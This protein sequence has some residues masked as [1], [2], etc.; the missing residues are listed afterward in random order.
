MGAIRVQ[1][2][3]G[4]GTEE[5]VERALDRAEIE[6]GDVAGD[7]PAGEGGRD[8]D[9]A[10]RPARWV[11]APPR[12]RGLAHF[13]KAQPHR[14]I[15]R[16]GVSERQPRMTSSAPLMMSLQVVS[17]AQHGERVAAEPRAARPPLGRTQRLSSP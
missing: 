15:G 3:L 14:L 8:H 11:G 2:P 5:G 10:L 16:C 4:A 6:G 7:E 9:P 12:R 17:A 13:T 1:D